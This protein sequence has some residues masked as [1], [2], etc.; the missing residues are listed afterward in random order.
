MRCVPAAKTKS[1][2]KLEFYRANRFIANDR[3]SKMHDCIGPIRRRR[4]RSDVRRQRDQSVNG[5]CIILYGF[6]A[7]RTYG[8]DIK[9][10]KID[11]D[12]VC[13]CAMANASKQSHRRIF[14]WATNQHWLFIM[15]SWLVVSYA[16]FF[17]QS[18]SKPASSPLFVIW[19]LQNARCR[20][21]F[22]NQNR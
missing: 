21:A 10:L 20:I 2:F 6:D 16:L 14:I 5:Y 22:L 17:S 13:V 9:Q 3:K 7:V 11:F 8:H 4:E 15:E 12:M 19:L 1:T 18:T